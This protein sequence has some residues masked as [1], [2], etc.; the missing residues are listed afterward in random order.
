M[1][2]LN[3]LR[4]KKFYSL[5]TKARKNP[6]L[7]T[8]K[9][10]IEKFVKSALAVEEIK[11]MITML[12]GYKT[13]IVAICMAALVAA[14]TLGYIDEETYQRLLALLASGGVATVAAKINRLNQ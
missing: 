14:K 6:R 2:L 4:I 12:Q 7:L 11:D 10:F 5:F 8:D 1:S 3:L 13:Y 9:K